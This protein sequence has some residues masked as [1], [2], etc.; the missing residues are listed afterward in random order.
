MHIVASLEQSLFLE[1]AIT[2]LEEKGI[3]KNKIVAVPLKKKVGDSK[4]FDTIHRADG[5]SLFDG[6]MILGTVFA[7]LGAI[8]GTVLK[9]GPVLWGIIGLFAGFAIGLLLDLLINKRRAA[10]RKTKP[11][12]TEVVLIINCDRE[13]A[14]MVERVLW[15]NQALGVGRINT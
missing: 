8:Y 2:E 13:Q 12:P 4:I 11:I 7:I 1:L 10:G 6:A 5:I 15:D 9:W 3:A 14:E